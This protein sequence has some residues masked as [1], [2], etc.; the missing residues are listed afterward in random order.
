MDAARRFFDRLF[1][2]RV[3]HSHHRK[4]QHPRDAVALAGVAGLEGLEEELDVFRF[5]IKIGAG[6]VGKLLGKLRVALQLAY[7]GRRKKLS[8]FTDEF[9]GYLYVGFLSVVAA[10]HTKGFVQNDGLSDHS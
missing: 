9:I 8:V 10:D 4:Q 2:I 6:R 3:A 5:D 1:K 7:L